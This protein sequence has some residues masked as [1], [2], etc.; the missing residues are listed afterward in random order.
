MRLLK[1]AHRYK[2]FA[3]DAILF[4]QSYFTMPLPAETGFIKFKGWCL[5][6]FEKKHQLIIKELLI[7]TTFDPPQFSSDCTFKPV[8]ICYGDTG[9]V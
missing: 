6:K 8:S 5:F 9:M 3:V 2:K 1:L 4:L 7:D